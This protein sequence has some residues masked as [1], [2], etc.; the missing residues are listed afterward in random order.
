MDIVRPFDITDCCVAF[1]VDIECQHSI[2]LIS[3]IDPLDFKAG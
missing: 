3:P 2:V 1:F